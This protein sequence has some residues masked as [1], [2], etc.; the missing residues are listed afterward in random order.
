MQGFHYNFIMESRKRKAISLETKYEILE[1]VKKGSLSKTEIAKQFDIQKSTLSTILKNSNNIYSAYKDSEF[2]NSR[3]K[4]R[5]TNY[6]EI[7]TAL[8]KWLV[9]ARSAG[10]PI[11]GPIL[12]IKAEEFG[13][14]LE[15]ENFIASN[16]LLIGLKNV[17]V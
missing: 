16:G 1:A 10:Y 13:K 4:L 9:G 8:F 14:L 6:E 7:D 2:G 3:K 12:K 5:G 11:S 15:F 17:T